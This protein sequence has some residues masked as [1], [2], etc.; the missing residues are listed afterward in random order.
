M[1]LAGHSKRVL[2]ASLFR[3]TFQTCVKPTARDS[4]ATVMAMDGVT[5]TVVR[6]ASLREL[7]QQILAK[8]EISILPQKV[9]KVTIN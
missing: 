4:G 2:T 1:I 6:Q 7:A 3:V 8:G 9:F 5:V